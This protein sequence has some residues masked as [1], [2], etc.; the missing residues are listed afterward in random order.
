MKGKITQLVVSP[1]VGFVAAGIKM[2]CVWLAL[3][4]LVIAAI[5][6]RAFTAVGPV[7]LKIAVS[8]PP[9]IKVP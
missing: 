4:S 7:L 2:V 5:V 3:A 1:T 9:A 6:G 8:L